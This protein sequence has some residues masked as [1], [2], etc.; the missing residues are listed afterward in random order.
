MLPHVLRRMKELGYPVF[1]GSYDL[2]I[3]GI[4]KRNGTPNKFD[5]TLGC[6]YKTRP[7]GGWN[8]HYW[9][10]STDPGRFYMLNPMNIKGTAILCPGHYSSIWEIDL[11]A[12]KYDA[13]CQRNG[14][15]TVW[16]DAN[17]DMSLDMQGPTDSGFFGINMHKAG[18]ASKVVERWSAGC[19][20][21]QY[22]KDFDTMMELAD[23][24]IATI[25]VKTFSYTLLEEW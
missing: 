5:D 22:A 18:R 8:I 24:Q 20:I 13:L 6:A 15:V 2:N 23:L 4:R 17:R 7:N 21:F 1:T 14:P 19:Q 12:G 3:F 10:G 11:H 16:R 25:G 9:D